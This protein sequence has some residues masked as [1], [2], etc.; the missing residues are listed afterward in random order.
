MANIIYLIQFTSTYQWEQFYLVMLIVW[1]AAAKDMGEKSI[2]EFSTTQL[3]CRFWDKFQHLIVL[4]VLPIE[5][6]IWENRLFNFDTL[7]YW[8]LFHSLITR[9]YL[10]GLH[11]EYGASDPGSPLESFPRHLGNWVEPQFCF[12]FFSN[13]LYHTF[14]DV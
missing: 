8:E 1:Y 9:F 13:I 10:Q 7:M 4:L 2:L 11:P 12:N 6:A 14:Y 5:F 3:R